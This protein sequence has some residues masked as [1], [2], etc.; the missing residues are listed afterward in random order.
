MSIFSE[1]FKKSPKRCSVIAKAIIPD[2][3]CLMANLQTGTCI[4]TKSVCPF[5]NMEKMKMNETKKW[6]TV[7][8]SF[9]LSCL[10]ILLLFGPKGD[11]VV[12]ILMIGGLF[13][14]LVGIYNITNNG[15]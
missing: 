15:G 10:T 2:G 13:V 3:V 6:V 8:C 1:Y 5:I 14:F 9:A 12:R 4:E 11:D 7:F